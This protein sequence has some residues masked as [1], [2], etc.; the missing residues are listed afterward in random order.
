MR[1][2]FFAASGVVIIALALGAPVQPA[3]PPG[4]NKDLEKQ[5]EGFLA[6]LKATPG[7][8][9]IETA[10]TGSGKQ[11]IFA[12]FE[13]KKAVLAWYYSDAHQQVMKQFFP[14]N[15]NS[16]RKPLKD[17][18][19]DSGPIMAVASLTVKGP[20]TKE[21]P[22]GFS[23]IAIE[24]YQ[25]LSGGLALGGK[26]APAKMKVLTPKPAAVERGATVRVTG[27]V[28]RDGKPLKAGGG[29]TIMVIFHP[30]RDDGQP[31]EEA[32]PANVR[33]SDGAYNVPGK[34]NKGIPSG[35]Y[36]ISVEMINPQDKDSL[37]GEFSRTKSKIIKEVAGG[38]LSIDI[39]KPGG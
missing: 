2:T 15:E 18:P 5:F 9:G 17:T 36:R 28:L 1:R 4:L 20:P 7:C 22:L 37:K 39:G 6:A 11:V 12:W 23:Q 21:N 3:D 24:L 14:G 10:T 32:Y 25:P 35:K 31:S 30:V 33:D 26:F 19:D 38:E 13:N 27:Q 16:K 34:Q 29:E 8:L